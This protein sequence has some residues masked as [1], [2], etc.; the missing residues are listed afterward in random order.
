MLFSRTLPLIR[1]ELTDSVRLA[2]GQCTCGLP[3][4]LLE[5]VEGRSEDTITLAGRDGPVRV[6]PNVFHAALETF[7]PNGWQVEQQPD[8]LTVRLVA[9]AGD[10]EL[11]LRRVQDALADLT[12]QA[13]AVEVVAVAELERTRLGKIQ[14]VKALPA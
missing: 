3:F 1:Y 13:T 6:H 10:T 4:A 9:P 12:I 7:A 8:R 14:L 5:S 11:A 2:T